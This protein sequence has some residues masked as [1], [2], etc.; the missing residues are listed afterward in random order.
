[1]WGWNRFKGKSKKRSKTV[2]QSAEV[3][4][5]I[6]KRKKLTG[7]IGQCS[8]IIKRTGHSKS[9]GGVVEKEDIAEK[10]KDNLEN[11]RIMIRK[12][13]LVS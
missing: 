11:V 12:N 9:V 4:G 5:W 8:D 3:S 7:M 13:N 10:H 1:M 6:N 2:A